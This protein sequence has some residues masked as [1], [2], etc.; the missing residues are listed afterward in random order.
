MKTTSL[1][2][3]VTAILIAAIMAF[4][5]YDGLNHLQQMKRMENHGEK[6]IGY[7]QGTAS[8]TISRRGSR[9]RYFAYIDYAG[10]DAG[11]QDRRLTIKAP[12]E[13]EQYQMLTHSQ[14]VSVMYESGAPHNAM[15]IGQKETS[16]KTKW[17]TGFAF[18]LF[19]M[20][21]NAALYFIF[22]PVPR[23]SPGSRKE[24]Y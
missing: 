13:K 18:A 6:T 11:G 3:S 23:F 12:V 20:A 14:Q 22:R 16:A 15:M 7:V 1:I 21:V 10:T 8:E 19:L 2:Y 9:V 5:I 17:V 24:P 4:K